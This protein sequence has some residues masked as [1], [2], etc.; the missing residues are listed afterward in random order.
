MAS[1]KKTPV[2]RER[3]VAALAEIAFDETEAK[4]SERMK[5]LELLGKHL[6]LWKEAPP[7]DRL[8]GELSKLSELL[9]Q[10]RA[11]REEA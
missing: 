2:S 3:V 5:A 9:E 4:L 8:E 1:R 7:E 6:G 11:L 10:R